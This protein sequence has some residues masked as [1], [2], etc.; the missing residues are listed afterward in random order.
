MGIYR[1]L[2]FILIFNISTLSAEKI[3]ESIVAKVN[4]TLITYSEIIQ[5]H[6]LLNMEKNLPR[7]TP[8]ITPELK[9]KLLDL[10]IMREIL[11]IKAKNDNV[12]VTREEI[13]KKLQF[14]NQ[15]KDMKSFI[16]KFD[17]SQLEL[18]IIAKKHLV[19]DRMIQRYIEK[20]FKNKETTSKAKKEALENWF[21]ELR[22][23]QRL[24][25]YSIP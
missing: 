9:K 18:K 25:L 10:I 14:Y 6:E 12:T 16:E 23:R 3:I 13:D 20:K 8:L 4:N 22:K 5:E 1:I 11:W 17:I 21:I 2:P 19:A 7:T 24:L 15:L